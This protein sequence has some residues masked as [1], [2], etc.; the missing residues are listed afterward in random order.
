MVMTKEQKQFYEDEIIKAI[1]EDDDVPKTNDRQKLL[2]YADDRFRSEY[3]RQIE[4]VGE[5]KARSEWLSG[6]AINIPY[7]SDDII[8][9]AK[10][11]GTLKQNASEK[12]ED[13][14]LDNYWN[15][16]SMQIEKANKKYKINE[17]VKNDTSK[18]ISRRNQTNMSKPVSVRQHTRKGTSTVRKHTRNKAKRY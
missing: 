18:A 8:A 17:P 14:I 10:A 12:Q 9:L 15:F 5:Q 1:K 3:G 4:R 16:M 11:S 6:L 2:K 7:M 13:K